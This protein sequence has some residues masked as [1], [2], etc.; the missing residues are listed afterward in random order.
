MEV[1]LVVVGALGAVSKRLDTWL[2]KLGI[3]NNT[4]LLQKTAFGN[5]KDLSIGYGSLPWCNVSTTC[6][7]A[8]TFL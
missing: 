3:I 7:R 2:D 6:P 8:K 5:S 4:G 1:V